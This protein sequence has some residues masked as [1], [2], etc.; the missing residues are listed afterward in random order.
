M[1]LELSDLQLKRLTK[2]QS[3][4]CRGPIPISKR[5]P[6]KIKISKCQLIKVKDYLNKGKSQTWIQTKMKL[7]EWIVHGVK[8]NR[9]DLLLETP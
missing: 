8:I 4:D 7:S 2:I 9:Y 1:A 6:D 5:R 3:G